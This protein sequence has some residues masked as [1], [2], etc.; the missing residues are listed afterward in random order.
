MV[1]FLRCT[2]AV[3]FAAQTYVQAK[4]FH[5]PHYGD[6]DGLRMTFVVSNY[7]D[8]TATGSLSVYDPYGKRSRLPFE[9]ETVSDV[10]LTL[11]PNSSV[12]L[13]TQ[14]TSAPLKTGFVRVYLDQEEVSGVAIFKF[15]SGLE[16]S[17]LPS[18]TG[19]RFGLFV[20]RS[21]GLDTG[22]AVY[23][24][25]DQPINLKLYDREGTLVDERPFEFTG[26]QGPQVQGARFLSEL[27]PDLAAV[28]QGS[29]IVVSDGPFALLGLRFGGGI[30]STIPVTPLTEDDVDSFAK[31]WSHLEPQPWWRE[32]APYSCRQKENKNSPWRRVGL[33]D[34]GGSDPLSLIR[35]FGNGSYL[36]YGHMGFS[37]CTPLDKY[38]DSYFLDPPADPTYYSLGD[39]DIWIDIARVPSDAEG[40]VRDDGKRVDFSMEQAVALMNEYVAPY[41]RRISEGNFRITFHEGNEFTVEGQ[42]SPADAE[43]QQYKSVGACLDGCNYGAPGGLNRILLNDVASFTGGQADNGW[44]RF[45]LASFMNEN[46]ETIVHEIGHGWMAW[47]HS[48][49]EVPWAPL[50][51]G[52]IQMPNPYSNHYDIMSSLGFEP[53]LGWDHEM[54]STLAINRYAA[55][56]IEPGDVALHLV[57]NAT[58]TLSKPRE[59]GYQFL[60][61]HSGRPHA[62][63][64][65]EVLEER[66]P[67]FKAESLIY[68]ASVRGR[69]RPRRYDGVLVS[70]YDQTAGTGASTRVGPALYNKDNPYFLK[71][72]GAGQDDYSLIVDGESRDIGGGI[73]VKVRKNRDGSYDVA[74]SGGKV[75]EFEVW[76]SNI[77]FSKEYDTGCF[78][79]EAVWTD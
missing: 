5:F 32:S 30:L 75:A 31:R 60:V 74:V 52:E 14:G 27:F 55:G 59:S 3:L 17:V 12:I 62:F 48:F 2:L 64:T 38:P 77:W 70:R 10:A 4:T 68:D 58:Y 43:N 63:T 67:R 56:W 47:P 9:N 72:V 20:E 39:L 53:I 50:A 79:D 35:Y 13:R 42:G 51:D 46:M 8:A 25:T 61:V 1:T 44:G 66:S 71:D 23:R 22:I 78:L 49:S 18:Q 29:L 41:F 69:Y 26:S 37:G 15:T 57:E 6:G 54:P 21:S 73:S 36:R 16:A 24:E 40:W 19:K 45:G 7:S 11:A 76:C 28:F 65:L 33:R 34:L